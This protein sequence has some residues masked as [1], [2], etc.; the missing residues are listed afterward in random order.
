MF[1]MPKKRLELAILLLGGEKVGKKT[2]GTVYTGKDDFQVTP[3]AE[4]LFFFANIDALP[5][6]IVFFTLK[7]PHQ[8]AKPLLYQATDGLLLCFDV[9]RKTSLNDLKDQLNEFLSLG[10]RNNLPVRLVGTKADL[11]F[12]RAVSSGHVHQLISMLV[13]KLIINEHEPL[14]YETSALQ[15]TSVDEPLV[16]LVREIVRRKMPNVNS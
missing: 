12:D 6:K 1:L 7:P 2:L 3:F 15:K 16:A 4:K 8:T 13:T 10:G 9:A 14:Y 5:L 11:V